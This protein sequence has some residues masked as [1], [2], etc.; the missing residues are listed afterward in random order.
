[1]RT[2][3]ASIVL[4]LLGR[5][6][7]NLAAQSTVFDYQGQWTGNCLPATGKGRQLRGAVSGNINQFRPVFMVR[8]GRISAA[9]TTEALAID[10][11]F[12]IR[13]SGT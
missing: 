13:I 11:C 3:K 12:S 5:L 1:M 7:P 2:M 6:A 4:L 10:R 9:R 8:A